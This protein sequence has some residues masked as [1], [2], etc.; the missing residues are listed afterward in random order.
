MPTDTHVSINS[1]DAHF[2]L[3]NQTTYGEYLNLSQLLEA[4]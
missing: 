3:T 4:R 1:G 2:D